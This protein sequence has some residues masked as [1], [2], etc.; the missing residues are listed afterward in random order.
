MKAKELAELLLKNPDC[1]V[2]FRYMDT[3]KNDGHRYDL[4]SFEITGIF[5]IGYSEK[6]LILDGKEL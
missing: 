3:S 2:E 5:D 1:D 6:I 4:K